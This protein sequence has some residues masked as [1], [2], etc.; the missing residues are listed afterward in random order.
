[1]SVNSAWTRLTTAEK[2]M[3][4]IGLPAGAVAL[5]ILYRRYRESQD[6]HFVL[7]GDNQIAVDMKVPRDTVKVIIGRQG[8]TIKR[9]R[10][11]TGAR[12]EIEDSEET[13]GEEGVAE[14]LL[15][16]VGSP[17]QVCKAKVAI[18]QLLAENVKIT[19]ELRV[20][21]RVVGRII[22]RGGE[23]IRAICRTTGAKVECEKESIG[24][25]LDVGR[26]VR[27]TGTKQEVA[28][29]KALV[30]AKM[31]EEAA[32]RQKLACSAA[33]RR[34]RKHPAGARL[35]EVSPPSPRAWTPA[36]PEGEV[37][38]LGASEEGEEEYRINPSVSV[39]HQE[40]EEPLEEG[41]RGGNSSQVSKFENEHLEVYVSASENPSHFWI[42]IL[43]SRCL[44][45][46]NLT[47]EMSRY[48]G[49]SI[50]TGEA[51]V[52]KVG[53]I[54]AAPFQSDG[55]WYRAR[56][57][58]YLENGNADLYYV[59]YGDNGEAAIGNM[60][61]LR[62]DF[63]SLPFQAVEC[64]LDGIQPAGEKWS[65]EAMN[66]FDG[67]AYCAEWKVLL[68]RIC[69][70]SQSGGVTRPQVQLFDRTSDKNLNIGDELVRLGHAVRCPRS[71]GAE[72]GDAPDTRGKA[73]AVSLQ[74]LLNDVTGGADRSLVSEV[75]AGNLKLQ[76]PISWQSHSEPS[77]STSSGTIEDEFS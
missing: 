35:E 76:L 53:D 15:T 56:V 52:P 7:V 54:V 57:L 75:T 42:Q 36:S 6:E 32:F 22:G 55:F 16:I 28:A 12:I 33:S 65:E 43:G 62:S 64:S 73:V 74:T 25:V 27:I 40:G 69:S 66:C 60:Q 4:A 23:C 14:R 61:L 46:D 51:F 47:Y 10:K 67:L 72:V 59:D 18:H 58:G 17:V 5:Y 26:L 34:H 21:Q 38:A 9:L 45:L 70:Y 41:Q 1:M 11:E 31:E 48:Y 20:P 29:A 49:S 71:D 39:E 3:L 2:V 44:Q 37:W 24:H 63:L 19:E 77:V 50:G 8:S 68:A 30:V 13:N